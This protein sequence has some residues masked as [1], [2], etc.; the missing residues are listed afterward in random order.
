MGCGGENTGIL[1]RSRP[2]L[3]TGYTYQLLWGALQ[4]VAPLGYPS[5]ADT[6]PLPQAPRRVPVKLA[7]LARGPGAW[8]R[9]DMNSLLHSLSA[10]SPGSM[11]IVLV[12]TG[13]LTISFSHAIA[14]LYKLAIC[15]HG[16]IC[17][18]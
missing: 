8:Q 7:S 13:P 12:H 18:L 4:L 17:H 1:P 11:P 15:E 2:G 14:R 5:Q 10:T 9:K 16:Q 3:S 6:V